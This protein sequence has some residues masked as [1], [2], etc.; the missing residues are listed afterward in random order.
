MSVTEIQLFQLLKAKLGEQEAKQL[1]SFVKEEVRSEFDNKRET[2]ATKEDIAN[3]KEYILQLKSE[4]LKFI[5][6]VGLIQFLAIV[7]A[8]I[9]FIN[10]M[11]K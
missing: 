4:L 6:L 2:L 8:V 7:G 3:T 11:M 1:V 10:F 9:G 5:Y